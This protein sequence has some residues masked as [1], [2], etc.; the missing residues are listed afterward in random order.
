MKHR[1][2][3]KDGDPA[4]MFGLEVKNIRLRENILAY[5]GAPLS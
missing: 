1:G 4:F 2:Q 5:F 3:E